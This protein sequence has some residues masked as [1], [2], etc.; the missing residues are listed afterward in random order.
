MISLDLGPDLF[1][2]SAGQPTSASVRIFNADQSFTI[3]RLDCLRVGEDVLY[4]G[5]ILVRPVPVW[6]RPIHFAKSVFGNVVVDASSLWPQG[7]VPYACNRSVKAVV[8]PALAHWMSLTP[9][10]FNKYQGEPDCLSFEPGGRTESHVG[11]VGGIQPLWLRSDTT[12]G[13]V[14]HEIGHALGL[15]HE[16][17][18][19]DRDLYITIHPE[20]Y[21]P[22]SAR[23]F[24]RP[25]SNAA[26]VGAYD[27]G[28]IM[29]YP[30]HAFTNNGKPTITL[31]NGGDI[32]QRNGLSPGDIAAVQRLYPTLI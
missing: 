2:N 3:R 23:Q 18:R 5:D 15:W 25:E 1:R 7:V 20:N 32:G 13:S 6:A 31:K 26:D 8:E 12:V 10:R 9:I 19:K 27:F 16:H 30:S 21:D 28:S 11:R 17:S 29:H 22:E 24:V 4:Q 14:I